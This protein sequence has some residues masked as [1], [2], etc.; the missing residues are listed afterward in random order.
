VGHRVFKWLQE[1]F[2]K[3]EMGQFFLFQET[4]RKLTEGI[5]GENADMGVIMA[6][7]LNR[8]VILF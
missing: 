1:V 3:F 6:T 5:Q 8:L 7:Y 2:L 4:H